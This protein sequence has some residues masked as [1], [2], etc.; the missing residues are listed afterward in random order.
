MPPS[1]PPPAPP[2]E[3]AAA[4]D[5]QAGKVAREIAQRVTT[6]TN[7][8]AKIPGA[9][10]TVDDDAIWQIRDER[11]CLAALPARRDAE[12]GGSVRAK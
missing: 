10:W 11:S 3:F 9:T 12:P 8:R 6:F 7:Y 1:P 4:A 2:T 5:T